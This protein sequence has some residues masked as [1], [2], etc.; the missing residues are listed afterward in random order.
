[1]CLHVACLQG[2]PTLV[3]HCY[4]PFPWNSQ[5]LAQNVKHEYAGVEVT[6]KNCKVDHY[7]WLRG[8]IGQSQSSKDTYHLTTG[9]VHPCHYLARVTV[10]KGSTYR[11]GSSYTSTSPLSLCRKSSW[12]V[13]HPSAVGTPPYT[14]EQSVPRV[15]TV[16]GAEWRQT[17][18]DLR[19]SP[20]GRSLGK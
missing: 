2:H 7:P 19:S 8:E 3:C 15:V 18:S 12:L 9:S 17:L 20:R 6:K 4:F 16:L 13:R 11:P 14:S 10:V 5:S 1:M